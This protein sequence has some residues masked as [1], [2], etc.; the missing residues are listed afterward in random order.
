MMP[1][2]SVDQP[3]E[4]WQ[5][6][7][8]AIHSFDSLFDLLPVGTYRSSPDGRQLR[9]NAALVRLNGY[10]N[11]AELLAAVSDIA[12]EW[13]VDPA[14]RGVFV[15]QIKRDGQLT[16]FVSEVYRHKSRERIWVSENA[17]MVFDANG[18]IVY[19]EGTVEDITE[20]M[21][22]V[23]AVAASERRY[24][25]LTE[26]A[27][28]ATIIVEPDGTITFASAGL[29]AL[30]GYA[31]ESF[32]GSN[33]FDT[34]HDADVVHHRA[35]L[36]HVVH[37]TNSGT[38]SIAQHRHRD[39]TYRHLASL[40]H[41]CSDD[42][43][44]GGVVVNWRDVTDAYLAQ[45]KLR[46]MAETDAL[47]RL[48]NR[49]QFEKEGERRLAAATTRHERVA[50]L[51]IDLNRFKI[52]NDAHG[53]ALGDALLRE[54]AT[55][56]GEVRSADETIARLGGDEFGALIPIATP[57]DA[58]RAARRYLS[59]FDALFAVRG[60]NFAMG[61]SIG[62]AVFPDDARSFHRL[63][64]HADLAM[65]TAKANKGGSEVARF[66]SGLAERAFEQLSAAT[67]LR[68]AIDGGQIVPY[69]QPIV[70]TTT[71]EW[72]GLEAVARWR[73]P[74]RGLLLPAEFINA[75]EEHRLIGALGRSIATQAIRDV[76]EWQRRFNI[77]LRLTI[78]VSAYQ[79][80]EV[81][82]APFLL[83]HLRQADLMPKR[84]FVE[85]TESVLVDADDASLG[86]INAL[87]AAGCRI[88]LD[89]LGAGFSSLAYLKR[90]PI[91]VVKLDRSFVQGV[92]TYR[93]DVAIVR[94]LSTL[95]RSLGIQ[96][97]AEGIET[98]EQADFLRAEG[99]IY[100]QG[101]LFERPIP[102][103]EVERQLGLR[104]AH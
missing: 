34:M 30:L 32:V 53:H 29:K 12:T 81:D 104:V 61:A 14:R 44:V 48:A 85:L 37:G 66:E 2:R 39:G 90:I 103:T 15:A 6:H 101:F 47:T 50:M 19:F 28:G 67:D 55:R 26:R 74:Y 98:R 38:E 102:P 99:V 10:S 49:F 31:P 73:H 60:L 75:A 69:Y 13:Y 93:T 1:N 36:Q 23:S 76:R 92:P 20:R 3:F 83:D 100:G 64:A 87:R 57:E 35:E 56:L 78:N 43:A 5:Q 17:H 79:L 72:R 97:V 24:R 42:P 63:L 45:K 41:N 89:D 8:S 4:P 21:Q 25:A 86:T 11:E 58:E 95:A 91:D 82:F 18:D 27:Q 59:A 77:E 16:N 62:V 9:A 68:A 52:I 22:T 71:G 46:E 7:V 40:A 54:V 84:L 80:R 33:V 88:V 70:D 51:F 94:A 96:V 65:F